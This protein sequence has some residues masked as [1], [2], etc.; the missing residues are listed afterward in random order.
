MGVWFDDQC[1]A[2][3]PYSKC[4][5]AF[6]IFGCDS[7]KWLAHS[8]AVCTGERATPPSL[9]RFNFSKY[10]TADVF[11]VSSTMQRPVLFPDVPPWRLSG[12]WNWNVVRMEQW[13]FPHLSPRFLVPHRQDGN[14]HH[15][16]LP[17]MRKGREAVIKFWS[18]ASQR[19]YTP[20]AQGP[21]TCVQ[22]VANAEEAL[23]LVHE[24]TDC[25]HFENTII[26]IPAANHFS[27]STLLGIILG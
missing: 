10:W 23:F 18:C 3:V 20:V 22:W 26:S 25:P 13:C 27:K 7:N 8:Q 9:S 14:I 5:V 12:A 4:C 2:R 16:S 15:H 19:F 21:Q 17:A 11:A 6:Q 1:A 24:H